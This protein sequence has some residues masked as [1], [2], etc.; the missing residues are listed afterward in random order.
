MINGT[1]AQR[2]GKPEAMDGK[3]PTNYDLYRAYGDVIK[4]SV[5]PPYLI[6]EDDCAEVPCACH[7]AA[8]TTMGMVYR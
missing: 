7:V 4:R 5:L 2:L 3:A 6:H 1:P 8:C